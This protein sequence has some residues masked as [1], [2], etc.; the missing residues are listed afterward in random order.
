[1]NKILAVRNDTKKQW[2]YVHKYTN[3]PKAMDF[4][5]HTHRDYEI[6]IFVKGSA[7]FL[8]EGRSYTLFPY[9]T[10]LIRGSELHRILPDPD[11]EYERIVISISEDFFREW[12]CEGLAQIFHTDMEKRF[13]PSETS[14]SND[15]D[16]QITNIE[17]Y[18]R[19][20]SKT[21]DTVVKCAVIELLHNL[22][23]LA[24]DNSISS[25]NK[26]VS[27]IIEYI[28]RNLSRPIRLDDLAERFFLSKY[29]MCRIFKKST[30]FTINRY[31]TTKR[32]IL[33]R[34]L[35]KNGG[36]LIEAGVEAG[37]GSYTN[38]YKAY[39]KEFGQSPKKGL[40]RN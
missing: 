28:N 1:M 33:A 23:S 36:N 13:I 31:I 35:Y 12:K 10:L 8:L 24:P 4:E 6:F 39:I 20:T 7:S 25:Q 19:E 30:G 3:L 37:F 2:S 18:I 32:L 40:K 15:I 27:K 29:Y 17:K 38:F 5:L 26:T 21:D 11:S 9:D 16:K 34:Q 22:R 14:L